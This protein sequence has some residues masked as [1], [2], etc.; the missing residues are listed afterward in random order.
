MKVGRIK[1]L[2]LQKLYVW[3]P[4]NRNHS[5]FI[6]WISVNWPLLKLCNLIKPS[7][8]YLRCLEK[9][10]IKMRF[11]INFTKTL[12][13][14]YFVVGGSKNLKLS[15]KAIFGVSFQKKLLWSFQLFLS[16]CYQDDLSHNE[17]NKIA[18]LTVRNFNNN[19]LFYVEFSE[20]INLCRS[21]WLI[22][23]LKCQL[24]LFLK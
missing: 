13:D 17:R 4:G 24:F 1:K 20:A 8:W 23:N 10:A 21:I 6:P 7:V 3:R 15:K 16:V 18:S 5:F 9:L 11:P 22:K 14:C 12:K 2:E 19:W